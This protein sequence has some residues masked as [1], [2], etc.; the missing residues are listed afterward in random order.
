MDR[1][2]LGYLASHEW[3]QMQGGNA[4]IG[5]TQFAVEQLTDLIVIELPAVGTKVTAGKT[6]GEIESVKAV[7]DLYAPVS[8]QVI[9]VNS[10]VTSNIQV[11]AEDP[12]DQGW[13]IKVKLDQPLQTAELLDLDAYEKKVAEEAH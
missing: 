12:F 8:G 2:S 5:I 4:T 3:V 13:L 7:S 10:N 6:F 1:K 11:L 9:E